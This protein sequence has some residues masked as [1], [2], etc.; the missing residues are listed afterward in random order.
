M[1]N[2]IPCNELGLVTAWAATQAVALCSA[3]TITYSE[4]YI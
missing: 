3:Y 2:P 4:Y 1:A